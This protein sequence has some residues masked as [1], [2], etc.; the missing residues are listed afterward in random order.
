M[1]A[2]LIAADRTIMT[3]SDAESEDILRAKLNAET[4]KL[5]WWELERHFARGVLIKVAVDQ[6]LVDVALALA[7]DDRARVE[8][9]LAEGGM[10]RASTADA[11]AWHTQGSMFW[12]VVT[13]PWVLVQEVASRLD[14]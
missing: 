14:G 12:A 7:R 9:L 6:D 2:R 4:G 10:A 5:A 1:P 11:Q 8:R 3:E 13:A